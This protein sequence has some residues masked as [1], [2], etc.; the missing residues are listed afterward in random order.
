M[1][2]ELI[3]ASDVKKSETKREVKRP[4]MGDSLHTPRGIDIIRESG[5]IKKLEIVS[6]EDTVECERTKNGMSDNC[7]MCQALN[8]EMF[9]R[10]T[11]KW[12]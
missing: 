1:T 5:G 12:K 10:C 4:E 2:L 3:D 6:R 7:S 8:S 11:N 9:R